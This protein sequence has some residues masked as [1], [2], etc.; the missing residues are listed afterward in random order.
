[1]D[2]L[3]D[4]GLATTASSSTGTAKKA[5]DLNQSDFLALMT[6][7]LSQ[8]DPFEPQDN[9][10][11]IAQMAQFSSLSAMDE[12][13]N[14]FT[15]LAQSLSQG[16]AVQAATLV[17]RNV[18]VP[19]EFTELTDSGNIAGS[20][21]LDRSAQN[22]TIDV[23]NQ[24]G[25]TVNQIVLESAS[26]GLNDFQ[27]DGMLANGSP[28]PA[29]VYEFR[30]TATGAEVGAAAEV[31]LDASINSVSVNETGDLMLDVVGIGEIELED[32]R[33]IN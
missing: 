28:A 22:V 5:N 13:T 6:E 3:Q 14:S 30:A 18:L 31:Y 15:V 20:V 10:D 9:G 2:A 27:W 23:V 7:Q 25:E 29:G 33:R 19:T 32:I 24:S 26:A 1:M 4:L 16:Q 17:G 8:Q 12:L 21:D 11:F